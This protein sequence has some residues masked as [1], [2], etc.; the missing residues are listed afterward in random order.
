M[1]AILHIEAMKPRQRAALRYT[2]K[3]MMVSDESEGVIRRS[4]KR[5]RAMKPARIRRG[6]RIV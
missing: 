1:K 6:G 3:D 5:A 2:L 4:M